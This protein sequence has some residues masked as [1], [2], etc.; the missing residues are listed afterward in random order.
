DDGG[1]HAGAGDGGLPADVLPAR[2]GNGQPFLGGE[3]VPGRATPAGPIGR[4][5]GG[6]QEHDDQEQENEGGQA[7]GHGGRLWFS[8][9]GKATPLPDGSV[10]RRRNSQLAAGLSGFSCP[11]QTLTSSVFRPGFSLTAKRCRS[12]RTP[13]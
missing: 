7:A 2:P 9:E 3:A 10:I 1:A 8:A 11:W 6:R 5:E 12:S 13:L 4:R